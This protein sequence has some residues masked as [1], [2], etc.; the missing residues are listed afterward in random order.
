M[1]DN[2]K[3]GGRANSCSS[4]SW[5]CPPPPHSS[6]KQRS[7]GQL[8]LP[9]T[10]LFLG[11]TIQAHTGEH[12]NVSQLSCLLRFIREPIRQDSMCMLQPFQGQFYLAVVAAALG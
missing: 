10:P 7:L 1:Q 11:N 8:Y 2:P 4:P 12:G 3:G 9:H 5:S 6:W